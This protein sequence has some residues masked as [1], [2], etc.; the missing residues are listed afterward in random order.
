M[1]ENLTGSCA[2]DYIGSG[3]GCPCAQVIEEVV[4]NSHLIDEDVSLT[5]DMSNNNC[6]GYVKVTNDSVNFYYTAYLKCDDY[7][8]DDYDNS[9]E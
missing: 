4:D 6:L 1:T 3:F 9:Y 2:D 5:N 7:I 8:S